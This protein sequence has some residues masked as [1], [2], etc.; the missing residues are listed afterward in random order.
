MGCK[1]R[2]EE[3][4]F[5]DGSSEVRLVPTGVT[6]A[7]ETLP[8]SSNGM[9]SLQRPSITWPAC[10]VETCTCHHTCKAKRIERCK[11]YQR[12]SSVH[13]YKIFLITRDMLERPD[14]GTYL[15]A[16]PDAA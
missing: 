16:K 6:G 15:P 8:R 11:E 1:G 9:A 14:T 2:K 13:Q 3:D 4:L 7:I 5:L 10:T 12:T